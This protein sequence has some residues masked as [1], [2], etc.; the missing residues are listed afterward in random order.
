M[1]NVHRQLWGCLFDI[2]WKKAEGMCTKHRI[3]PFG[4]MHALRLSLE[5]HTLP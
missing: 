2:W 4:E 1:R 5:V 3:G